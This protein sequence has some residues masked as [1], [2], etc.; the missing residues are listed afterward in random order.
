[1][2]IDDDYKPSK[3]HAVAARRTPKKSH[4]PPPK[5]ILLPNHDIFKCEGCTNLECLEPA[6]LKD[7]IGCSGDLLLKHMLNHQIMKTD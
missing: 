6:V 4:R 7:L 5:D 3:S 1:M 2:L